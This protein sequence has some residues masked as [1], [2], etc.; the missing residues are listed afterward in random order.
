MD[1]KFTA[2]AVSIANFTKSMVSE[3]ISIGHLISLKVGGDELD[4]FFHF[5]D[6]TDPSTP[7]AM[8]AMVTSFY[9]NG[10]PGGR[11]T[12][13]GRVPARSKGKLQS[14]I[15]TK[16]KSAECEFK[17]N[18]YAPDGETNYYKCFH[19]DDAMIKCKIIREEC[20]VSNEKATDYAAPNH[21]FIL[22]VDPSDQAD[23]TLHFDH[24]SQSINVYPYG[25]KVGAAG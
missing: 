15:A 25:G 13:E 16:T 7:V 18:F 1:H 8:C 24:G 17:I 6:P 5:P 12:I 22:V 10:E 14:A 19:T 23:Q 3:N 20:W 4:Q 21:K 2:D 11:I 9:W